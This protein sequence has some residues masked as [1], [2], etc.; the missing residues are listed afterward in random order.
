MGC[1]EPNMGQ[2]DRIW[3]LW[4]IYDQWAACYGN[5]LLLTSQYE[6][7]KFSI[8]GYIFMKLIQQ[9]KVYCIGIHLNWVFLCI[10]IQTSSDRLCASSPA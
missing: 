10:T 8:L 7:D 4:E 6:N 2:R 5:K 1:F 9:S 3:D